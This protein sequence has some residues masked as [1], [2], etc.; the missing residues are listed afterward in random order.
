[1]SCRLGDIEAIYKLIC[2]DG[3]D[4]FTADCVKASPF[5][6]LK[7]RLVRVRFQPC[8]SQPGGY[9]LC[10]VKYPPN[11]PIEGQRI[12][13]YMADGIHDTLRFFR[14]RDR[15]HRG[16]PKARDIFKPTAIGVQGWNYV[17]TPLQRIVWQVHEVLRGV[18]IRIKCPQPQRMPGALTSIPLSAIFSAL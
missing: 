13:E 12:V 4:A 9:E 11:L 18:S 15:G 17:R 5:S 7:Q 16:K 6:D 14:R 8:D 1:V 10:G 3:V 2:W